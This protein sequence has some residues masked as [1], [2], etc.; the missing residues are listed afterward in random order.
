M[1]LSA[2][3]K[4]AWH[5]KHIYEIMPVIM[6]EK[7]MPYHHQDD[8]NGFSNVE[9]QVTLLFHYLSLFQGTH[10]AH[11]LLQ[12]VGPVWNLQTEHLLDFSLV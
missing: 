2:Y 11:A 1:Y 5:V 6:S 9:C 10:V 3:E 8:A 12:R 7:T 4:E